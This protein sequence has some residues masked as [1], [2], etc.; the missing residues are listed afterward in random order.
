[1]SLGLKF[2]EGNVSSVDALGFYSTGAGNVRGCKVESC[3]GVKHSQRII[4]LMGLGWCKKNYNVG[5]VLG[6]TPGN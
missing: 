3:L 2:D 5:A 6:V 1:M 4:V